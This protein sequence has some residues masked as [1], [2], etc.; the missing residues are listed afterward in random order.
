MIVSDFIL[1]DTLLNT[2]NL[3]NR[4]IDRERQKRKEEIKKEYAYEE[5]DTYKHF[6]NI[7]PC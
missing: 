3:R 7:K 1:L 5:N 4:W 6:V 2:K